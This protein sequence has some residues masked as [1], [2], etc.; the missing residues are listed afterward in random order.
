[1][2]TRQ[3]DVEI[4]TGRR[5][6]DGSLRLSVF[7]EDLLAFAV[8]SHGERALTLLLTRTQAVELQQALTT[9]IRQLPD[10]DATNAQATRD[11]RHREKRRTGELN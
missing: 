2:E 6:P 1:M 9:L 3:G 7:A 8:E 5:K 4:V 10:E 11:E